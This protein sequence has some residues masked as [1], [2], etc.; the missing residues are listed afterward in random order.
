VNGD[1]DR[2]DAIL[3]ADILVI[4]GKA[5]QCHLFHSFAG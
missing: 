1:A 4:L 2:G 3:D 5:L